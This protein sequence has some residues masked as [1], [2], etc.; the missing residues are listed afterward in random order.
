MH[1]SFSEGLE[2]CLYE[3]F[4]F[5]SGYP[6]IL[7]S[8]EGLFG[9]NDPCYITDESISILK[10]MADAYEKFKNKCRNGDHGENVKFWLSYID[11]VKMQQRAQTAIQEGDFNARLAA[12]RWFLPYYFSFSMQ[13][14]ARY[15][16][17]YVEF[18][19][20][21]DQLHPGLRSEFLVGIQAQDRYPHMTA[22]DQRGE[23]T[24]NREAKVAGGMQDAH[25]ESLT[26]KWSLKRRAAAENIVKLKQ[27]V[28]LH[29]SNNPYYLTTP[30]KIMQSEENTS[31]V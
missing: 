16:S 18:L 14:Y 12:W 28:G 29:K 22:I 19:S 31:S 8:I 23:Q 25:S 10:E 11:F 6:E 4:R 5:E 27:M 15:A 3:R 24:F 30:I 13:N 20:N 2:R 9:E 21:I 17:F 7:E 1:S 26:L